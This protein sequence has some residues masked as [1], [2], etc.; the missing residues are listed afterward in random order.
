MT[1]FVVRVATCPVH[2]DRKGS[3][4]FGVGAVCNGAELIVQL[5]VTGVGAIGYEV[6][7]GELAAGFLEV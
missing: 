7:L 4:G 3:T 5:S 1:G 2:G 6:G